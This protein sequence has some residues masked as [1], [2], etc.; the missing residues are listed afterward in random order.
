VARTSTIHTALFI[1][2]VQLLALFS[3]KTLFPLFDNSS[4]EKDISQKNKEI[5]L[6]VLIM[7]DNFEKKFKKTAASF[8]KIKHRED[9]K[10]LKI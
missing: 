8:Q 7:K 4:V 9:D 3:H 2:L 10:R 1:C 6:I 5:L